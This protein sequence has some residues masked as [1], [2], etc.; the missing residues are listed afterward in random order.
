MQLIAAMRSEFMSG[1]Q[2]MFISIILKNDPNWQRRELHCQLLCVK[3]N[4]AAGEK[5]TAWKT[6][7]AS[8]PVR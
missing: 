7:M 1:Y 8:S 3:R 2:S 5:P 4:Y 6:A